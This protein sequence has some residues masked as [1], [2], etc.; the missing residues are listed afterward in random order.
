MIYYYCNLLNYNCFFNFELTQWRVLLFIFIY[1]QNTVTINTELIINYYYYVFIVNNDSIVY[2]CYW[3]AINLI[4]KHVMANLLIS[5]IDLI[6]WLD[7]FD[8]GLRTR[9][10]WPNSS[11]TLVQWM[12]GEGS[13]TARQRSSASVACEM[14]WRSGS[15][16]TV[17]GPLLT[18]YQVFFCLLILIVNY[19]FDYLSLLFFIYLIYYL[20][21]SFFFFFFLSKFYYLFNYLLSYL[22][23]YLFK[24]SFHISNVFVY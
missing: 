22:L 10:F 19:S 4:I 16:L 8:W 5:L 18:Q 7:A 9:T 23:F 21:F 17:G 1:I 6:W 15:I 14:V 2:L 24:L 11:P 12:V 3:S 13:P 20:F